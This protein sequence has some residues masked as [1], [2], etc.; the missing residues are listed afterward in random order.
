MLP[1]IRVSVTK[2]DSDLTRTPAS[3]TVISG[4]EVERRDIDSHAE[5]AQQVPNVYFTQW[6][7]RGAT[8]NMRGLGYSDDENDTQSG[9]FLID[10]V[11]MFGNAAQSLFDID[12]IEVVRGPQS[13]L[14]GIG[15]MSG[16]VVV[17]TR[18]AEP[19]SEGRLSFDLGAPRFGTIAGTLGGAVSDD[20]AARASL[21]FS[22][23][24]GTLTNTRT[25]AKDGA[26]NDSF[27]GRIRL[28]RR[29]SAGGLLKLGLHAAQDQGHTDIWATPEAAR[30]HETSGSDQGALNAKFNAAVLEYV[31][32]L[33][34]GI[35]LTDIAGYVTSDLS[36][37]M[38]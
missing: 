26:G 7:P 30:R 6:A 20:T 14:Y 27:A 19:V 9:G 25:G 16:L 1:E 3:V 32:S 5:I 18:D 33:S 15:A 10:G 35:T 34:N 2:T 12:R 22:S 24:D 29:L 13:T 38:P 37:R 28:T 31:Q 4:D 11:P 8:L 21:R 36:T 17:R 23:D